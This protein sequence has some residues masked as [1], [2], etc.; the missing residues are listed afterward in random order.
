LEAATEENKKQKKKKREDR[1]TQVK[2]GWKSRRTE[3][4]KITGGRSVGE[5]DLSW[6]PKRLEVAEV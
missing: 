3:D 4:Q 1:K 5:E 6:V 2:T